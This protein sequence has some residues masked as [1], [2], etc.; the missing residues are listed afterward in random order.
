MLRL[1]IFTA[2][3]LYKPI[4]RWNRFTK[5]LETVEKRNIFYL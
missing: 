5:E 2:S 1:D 3:P 4:K